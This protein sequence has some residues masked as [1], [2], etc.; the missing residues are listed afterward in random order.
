MDSPLVI[1]V[2]YAKRRGCEYKMTNGTS[3]DKG[4]VTKDVATD[5]DLD[6]EFDRGLGVPAFGWSWVGGAAKG[7]VRVFGAVAMT[8]S[9]AVP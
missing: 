4:V 7:I 9:G 5:A 6:A 2:K 8:P 3:A 1:R